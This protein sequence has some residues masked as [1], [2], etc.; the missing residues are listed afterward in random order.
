ML[1][2]SGQPGE[3]ALHAEGLALRNPNAKVWSNSAAYTIHKKTQK[4]LPSVMRTNTQCRMSTHGQNI[5]VVDLAPVARL[6]LIQAEIER[7]TDA[8]LGR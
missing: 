6:W 7:Q 4:R 2:A 1:P 8:R 3:C 5:A